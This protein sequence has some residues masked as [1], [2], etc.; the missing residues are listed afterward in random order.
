MTPK[1]R[2]K[3]SAKPHSLAVFSSAFRDPGLREIFLNAA[4]IAEKAKRGTP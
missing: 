4:D 2:A 1:Q 3:T